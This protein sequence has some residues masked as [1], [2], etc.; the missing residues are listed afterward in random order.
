MAQ[1]ILSTRS[2]GSKPS[3][4]LGFITIIDGV[5]IIWYH[6]F[7]SKISLTMFHF[8][9]FFY[10]LLPLIEDKFFFKKNKKKNRQT[11]REKKGCMIPLGKLRF[12]LVSHLIQVKKNREKIYIQDYSRKTLFQSYKSSKPFFFLIS[13]L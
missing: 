1:S 4:L 2:W 11:I 10:I 13:H 3:L 6:S 9:F 5:H 12:N 7:G 8:R